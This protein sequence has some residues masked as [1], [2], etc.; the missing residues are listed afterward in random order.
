MKVKIKAK[1]LVILFTVICFAYSSS[2]AKIVQNKCIKEIAEVLQN[3]PKDL[4][5]QGSTIVVFDWD[6]TVAPWDDILRTTPRTFSPREAE[7]SNKLGTIGVIRALQEQGIKNIALTGRLSGFRIEEKERKDVKKNL[8]ANIQNMLKLVGSNE[9]MQHGAFSNTELMEMKIPG[10]LNL[11]REKGAKERSL[12]FI[13]NNHFVFAGGNIVKGQV[14]QLII[15]N[16]LVVSPDN[17]IFVDN[18][19]KN[20]NDVANKFNNSRQNVYIYYY[21]G[22][23]EKAA[24]KGC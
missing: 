8:D 6:D 19:E 4:S 11:S 9:W 5:K 21:P 23:K 24:G 18:D 1:Y 14:L 16:N 3:L 10:A 13:A 2:Q 20:T 17:I 12:Y 7:G 15:D 22:P